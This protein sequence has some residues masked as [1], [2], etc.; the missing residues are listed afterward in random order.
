MKRVQRSNPPKINHWIK[1]KND[2]DQVH[3]VIYNDKC[4]G[5]EKIEINENKHIDMESMRLLIPDKW[6]DDE[7]INN[8]FDL[9]AR[10]DQQGAKNCLFFHSTFFEQLFDLELD[11]QYNFEKVKGWSIRFRNNH[12]DII[13]KAKIFIPIN[14]GRWH[15][16]LVVI[17][18]K[19]KKSTIMT[20]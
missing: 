6:L 7:V 14:I 8:F 19:A 15:W 4:D 18:L 3:L 16:V 13:H 9:L 20:I 2:R 10:R 1:N 17:F 12:G 5:C 11:G